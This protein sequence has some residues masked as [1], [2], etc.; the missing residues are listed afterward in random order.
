MT[1]PPW[2]KHFIR[3]GLRIFG[4]GK[5][6]NSQEASSNELFSPGQ[7]PRKPMFSSWTS[8]LLVWTG[9]LLNHLPA[10]LL[11]S[12]RKGASFLPLTTISNPPPASSMSASC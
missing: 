5:S 12:Q 9:M 10:C 1:M 11:N 3:L 6:V 4:T 7:S 2:R 8:R